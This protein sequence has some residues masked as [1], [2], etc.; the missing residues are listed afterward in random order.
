[1]GRYTTGHSTDCFNCNKPL[2]ECECGDTQ[3]F[4]NTDG[5]VCPYCGEMNTACDSD[6]ML[7]SES[8]EDYD[9]GWC[10]KTFAVSVYVS[11]SWCGKKIED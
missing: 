7:Y 1:M 9:C 4:E 3:T 5:V 8:T 6:G 11:F 10:S 2:S